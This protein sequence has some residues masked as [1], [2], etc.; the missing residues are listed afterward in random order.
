MYWMPGLVLD[1]LRADDRGRDPVPL[2]QPDGGGGRLDGGLRRRGGRAGTQSAAWTMAC[3][4]IGGMLRGQ[5]ELAQRLGLGGGLGDADL[6]AEVGQGGEVILPG[7][8]GLL[9]GGPALDLGQGHVGGLG[10]VRLE[11][12]LE[13]PAAGCR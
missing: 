13:G 10:L 7:R 2:G 6:V 12:T 5:G 4:S 9:A 1:V 11:P 8:P 3:S